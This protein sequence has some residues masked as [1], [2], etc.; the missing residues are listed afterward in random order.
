MQ[1]SVFVKRLEE[2]FDNIHVLIIHVKRIVE[3]VFCY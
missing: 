3:M 1:Y 2:L